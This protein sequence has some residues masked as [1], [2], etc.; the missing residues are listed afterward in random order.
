MPRHAVHPGEIL[1]DELW[2]RNITPPNFAWEIGVSPGLVLQVIAGEQ[3]ITRDL[4][5]RLA[6]RFGTSA[7]FWINLQ[8]QFDTAVASKRNRREVIRSRPTELSQAR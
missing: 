6:R 2:Y 8:S 5:Q 4:A 7:Q 1:M 3:S